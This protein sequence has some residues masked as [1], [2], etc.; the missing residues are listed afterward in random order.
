MKNPELKKPKLNPCSTQALIPKFRNQAHPLDS[1]TSQE[2]C[3][4]L[5]P[6]ARSTIKEATTTRRPGTQ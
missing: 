2:N 5:P 1:G 6:G 4:G 3:R